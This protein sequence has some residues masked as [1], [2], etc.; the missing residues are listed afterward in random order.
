M[1]LEDRIRSLL[2][3]GWSISVAPG[4]LTLR[5]EGQ[6]LSYNGF[7]APTMSPRELELYIRKNGRPAEVWIAVRLGPRIEPDEVRRRREH[8]RILQQ[9]RDRM[10]HIRRRN[11]D[12]LPGS[13]AE[14]ALVDDYRAA[15]SRAAALPDGFYE[16][17]SVTLASHPE[18][19]TTLYPPS[20]H[21]EN[22]ALIR[23]IEGLIERY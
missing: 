20:L 9:M 12:Y 16:D 11:D 1:G 14:R 15:L 18:Y 7:S 13:S 19:P 22:Q 10:R 2:P 4:E 8:D 6:A 23:A 21:E 3:A 17:A 5:R